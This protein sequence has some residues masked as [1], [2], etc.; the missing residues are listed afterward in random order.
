MIGLYGM[1]GVGKTTLA[2]VAGKQA[3]EQKLFDKV[4]IVREVS[5]K[6]DINIRER[7][8]ELFGLE[9]NASTEEGKAKE[10]WRILKGQ[11]KILIILDDVWKELELRNIG[12]PFGGE[13]EGCKILL[14]TRLQQVCSQMDCQEEFKLNIQSD[15]EAWALFQ[16]EAGVEDDSPTLNVA[17]EVARECNGLPLAIVTAAKALKGK[18]L[19]GWMVANQQLKD[20]RYSNNEDVFRGI[21]Q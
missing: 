5:Q 6:A 21:V 7:I 20:S 14:T 13:H 17:K 1:P 3:M 8:A 10:L 9:F 16:D 4:M 11:K 18:E 19:N 12:I 15:D 2:E